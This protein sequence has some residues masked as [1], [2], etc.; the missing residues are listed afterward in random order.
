[1]KTQ[2]TVNKEA[3]RAEY[4][5]VWHKDEK[6]IDFCVKK[7]ASVAALP[8]GEMVI[9][10]KQPIEKSFCF[11]ESGYDYD[12]AQDMAAHAR[13]SEGYFKTENMKH[14]RE[15]IKDLSEVLNGLSNYRLTISD[16]AYYSQDAD[17]KLAGIRFDRLS[18]ILDACGGSA[19]LYELPGKELTVRGRECRIATPKEIE[20][21]LGA[22]TA[23]AEAHEKKVDSYLKRY[24][25]RNVRTWT[26]WRDA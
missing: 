22:Y 18:D 20:I 15:W 14:F 9:V 10:E 2:Y 11:G 12:E 25:M 5:K 16:T 4:A 19:D 21:I 24:G 6:M 7:A 3:L 8:T 17:C 23:A 13:K 26:Y 1:M